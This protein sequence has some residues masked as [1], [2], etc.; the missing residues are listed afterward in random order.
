LDDI[1]L[2]EVVPAKEV[3]GVGVFRKLH[4]D[5]VEWKPVVLEL[6]LQLG[7]WPPQNARR[8]S[9]RGGHFTLLRVR[10]VQPETSA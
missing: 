7:V 2:K 4:E 10:A 3:H 9:A 1:A 8:R 5:A 6:E